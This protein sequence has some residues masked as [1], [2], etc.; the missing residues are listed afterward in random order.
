MSDLGRRAARGARWFRLRTDRASI[1]DEVRDEVESH[2]DL[3]VDYLIA[4]GRSPTEAEREA[5][6]RFGTADAVHRLLIHADQQERRMQMGRVIREFL[7]DFRLSLRLIRRSP[8]FF[9][10]ALFILAV[11]V[12]ANAAVFSILQAALLQP[13]PYAHPEQLHMLWRRVPSS[14]EPGARRLV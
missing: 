13:L 9:A 8:G 14:T 10:S 5:R 2:I 6:Q 3:A 4:R 1:E 11:G 7:Q 12:G